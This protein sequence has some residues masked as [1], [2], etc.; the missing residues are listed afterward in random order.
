MRS[1]A[2]F[3]CDMANLRVMNYG[4]RAFSTVEG[5]LR[6]P[7]GNVYALEIISSAHRGGNVINH[8]VEALPRVAAVWEVCMQHYLPLSEGSS[9]KQPAKA[10][11]AARGPEVAAAGDPAK[12]D[13]GC[14]GGAPASGD[15]KPRE[16]SKW[17]TMQINQRSPDSRPW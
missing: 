8:E 16:L 9:G 2:S 6:L 1:V 15:P 17:N 12:R 4:R 7:S 3:C 11:A 5:R 14:G 10:S 13:R